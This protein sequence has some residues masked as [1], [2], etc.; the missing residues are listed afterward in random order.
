MA[1]CRIGEHA[2]TDPANSTLSAP[3]K[4]TVRSS[5]FLTLG[6]SGPPRSAP[7]QGTFREGFFAMNA[8][9]NDAP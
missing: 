6:W 5:A 2:I 1:A 8:N 3:R 9:R 4:M 7:F